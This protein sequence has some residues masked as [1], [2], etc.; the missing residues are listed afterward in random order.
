MFKNYQ[1]ICILYAFNS[2]VCAIKLLNI[3]SKKQKK[4]KYVLRTNTDNIQY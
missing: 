4:K 2:C 1:N 3:H